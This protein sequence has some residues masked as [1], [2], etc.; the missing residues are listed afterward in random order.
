[1]SEII[2]KSTITCPVCG[3]TKEEIMPT[4]ACQCQS[5]KANEYIRRIH[6]ANNPD[7]N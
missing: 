3:H 2:L 7:Q 5:T 4:D 1:M 6:F